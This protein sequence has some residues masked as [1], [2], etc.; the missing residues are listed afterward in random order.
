MDAML[1]DWLRD[2]RQQSD[3]KIT[4]SPPTPSAG[5]EAR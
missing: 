4:P 2:L 3:I 1:S 5:Q